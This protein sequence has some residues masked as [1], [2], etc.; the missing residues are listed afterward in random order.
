MSRRHKKVPRPAKYH[1]LL[2]IRQVSHASNKL[3]DSDARGGSPP[4]YYELNRVWAQLN[5]MLKRLAAK[6]R[7]R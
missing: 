3:R 1:V 2:A 5:S 6:Q 7:A 4:E